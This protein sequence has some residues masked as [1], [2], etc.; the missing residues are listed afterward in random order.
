MA[1][2]EQHVLLQFAQTTA[3][4]NII[5]TAR[6]FALYKCITALPCAAVYRQN[7][8]PNIQPIRR[9]SELCVPLTNQWK[10]S[11]VVDGGG[12]SAAKSENTDGAA[13]I[14]VLWVDSMEQSTAC[15]TRQ[16]VHIEHL[17]AP[18]VNSSFRT[19]Q[20][21]LMNAITILRR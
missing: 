13:G 14:R 9:Q 1:V 15:C 6:Q 11:S 21:G 3:T 19:E 5:T 8:A 7:C 10:M 12:L 20:Y 4:R 2:Y 18:H 16:Y 17:Q